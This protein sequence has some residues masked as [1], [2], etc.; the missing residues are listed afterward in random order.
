M[1]AVVKIAK[2]LHD[3]STY[4]SSESYSSNKDLFTQ[5]KSEKEPEPLCLCNSH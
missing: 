4:Y 2:T 3:L 1:G 5:L